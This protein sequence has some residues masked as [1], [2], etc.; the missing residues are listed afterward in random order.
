MISISVGFVTT[1]ASTLMPSLIVAGLNNGQAKVGSSLSASL[2]DG[3][4][5]TSFSWGSSP[6]GT[7]YSDT[8]TL[9]VPAS[10]EGGLIYLTVQSTVGLFTAVVS[11]AATETFESMISGGNDALVVESLAAPPT[12]LTLNLV[13]DTDSIIVEFS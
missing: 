12:Q 7:E 3:S 9:S 13:P 5:I 10:A 11:V 2:S 6:G 1:P 8:N 4:A